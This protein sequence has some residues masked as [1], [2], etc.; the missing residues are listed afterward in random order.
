MDYLRFKDAG[1]K[2]HVAST[3]NPFPVTA[4]TAGG[5]AASDPS[6]GFVKAKPLTK[7]DRSAVVP[8]TAVTLVPANTTRT[9]IIIQNLDAA[10]ALWIHLGGTASVGSLANLRIGPLERFDLT[11]TTAALSAIAQGSPINTT[12]WEF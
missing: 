11:G 10:Q 7:T 3:S 9:R 4:V 5:A 1:G 8:L 2:D 12:V 6:G